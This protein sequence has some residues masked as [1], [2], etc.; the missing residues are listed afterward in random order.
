MKKIEQARHGVTLGAPLQVPGNH[1]ALNPRRE[2]SG[3][4]QE[5]NEVG[6]ADKW[7]FALSYSLQM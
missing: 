1:K 7:A 2:S 5:V 4:N 6:I 3:K